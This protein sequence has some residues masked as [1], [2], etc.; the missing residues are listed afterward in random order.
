M[1]TA[2]LAAQLT[3]APGY[4]ALEVA[5]AAQAAAVGLRAKGA[6]QKAIASNIATCRSE[7]GM[8]PGLFASA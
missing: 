3:E 8:N 4:A 1:T 7:L 5:I 6:A 2:Q